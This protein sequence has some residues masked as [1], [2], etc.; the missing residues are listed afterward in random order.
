MT[1]SSWQ[2]E[3]DATVFPSFIFE[4]TVLKPARDR[5]QTNENRICFIFAATI[6][7]RELFPSRLQN[8]GSGSDPRHLLLTTCCVKGDPDHLEY[9]IS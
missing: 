9:S 1:F 8:V 4:F 7:Q 2:Q 3:Y 5:Q 6:C